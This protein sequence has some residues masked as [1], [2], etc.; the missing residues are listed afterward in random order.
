MTRC[1]N[2]VVQLVPSLKCETAGSHSLFVFGVVPEGCT[3]RLDE[4]GLVLVDL[5][6]SEQGRGGSSV[7]KGDRRHE[8]ESGYC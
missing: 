7:S 4:P 2:K 5:V 1:M 3:V 6:S 8:S